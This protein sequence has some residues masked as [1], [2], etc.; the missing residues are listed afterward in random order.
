MYL[1]NATNAFPALCASH[2]LQLTLSYQ[3]SRDVIDLVFTVISS[4][5]DVSFA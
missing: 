5:F 4:R 3:S 2:S 1:P